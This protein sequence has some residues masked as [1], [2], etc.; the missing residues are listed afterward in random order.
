MRASGGRK[1]TTK[2]HNPLIERYC[3]V[4]YFWIEFAPQNRH[5]SSAHTFHTTIAKKKETRTIITGYEKK[6]LLRIS[7]TPCEG[8]SLNAVEKQSQEIINEDT[9]V[10]RVRTIVRRVL[11]Y[12]RGN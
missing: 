4:T 1:R 10:R 5:E 3:A 12:I 8:G 6:H 11:R 7:A 2:K 9:G